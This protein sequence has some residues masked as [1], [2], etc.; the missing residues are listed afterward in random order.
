[1][2]KKKIAVLIPFKDQFT[3]SNAGSASIWI[4]DFNKR[5]SYKKSIKIYGNTEN[6]NDVIDK[7]NYKNINFN[8]Y[9]FKSKNITYVDH[10]IKLIKKENFDLI[11][12]HNRP[13]Y[14]HYLLK[15]NI[16]TKLILIFH[17]NPLALGGSKSVSERKELLNRCEKLIFVS[18]WVMEKFFHG[19]DRKS[20]SKCIVIY[21]SIDPIRRFPGKKNIISFVG[22]LNKS[23]GF[24]LFGYVIVRI[25]NKYKN[26]KGVIVGDEPREKYNFKHK[27]LK[28]MGWISHKRTLDLYSQ[29]S[30]SV[31]PS[32]WD[33]PFGRTSME[34]ASRGCAT[35]ISKKGGLIETVPNA[36]YLSNLNSKSLFNKIEK[37]IQNKK[38]RIKLQKDSYKNVFHNL[39]SNTKKID[40]Y[41]DEI[42]KEI[43]FSVLKKT[44]LKII[45]I[46]NFGNRL[47]NRLYF[48]SIAK[49]ISNGL[50]RLG[51]DVVNIS[52]RDTIRF[53]RTVSA[54]TGVNYLNKLFLETVKN[55]SPDLII[56]GHSDNLN[57]ETFEQIRKMKKNIKII[58]WFEDNLHASGPDPL[59]NQERLLKYKNFIDLH[60]Q[61]LLTHHF[62]KS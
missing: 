3:N 16:K 51:H 8:N 28:Y 55:Y 23:K 44:R 43:N 38:E 25:L 15:K 45:H 56:L 52:D 36:V 58:Q 54:K 35:I 14:I 11:E 12:I 27:N 20:D 17:N 59:L 40:L 24:H 22:K 9:S 57:I 31:A 10:F 13:S 62:Y 5:S 7:K 26:W 42:F 37:L 48:I 49:K 46:S 19:L 34:A 32:F 47:F 6:I 39:N 53:N 18:N 2:K 4:K 21:P 61:F 29:T 30:I 50:I 41:R 33:E 60:K 1:M